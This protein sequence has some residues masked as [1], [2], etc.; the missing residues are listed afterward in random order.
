MLSAAVEAAH[1]LLKS[2]AQRAKSKEQRA[3]SKEQRAKSKEQRAKSKE[4]GTLTE[5]SKAKSESKAGAGR[6]LRFEPR[7]SQGESR[8]SGIQRWYSSVCIFLIPYFY[9]V[10]RWWLGC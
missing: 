6:I 10:P 2:K 8:C 5:K 7:G 4:R 9:F 1:P 3:K